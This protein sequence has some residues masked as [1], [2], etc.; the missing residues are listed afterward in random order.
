MASKEVRNVI[1]F[2]ADNFHHVSNMD[3]GV[4]IANTVFCQDGVVRNLGETSM[5]NTFG[6]LLEK[7]W[8]WEQRR[9]AREKRHAA[10][11]KRAEKV[12]AEKKEREKRVRAEKAASEFKD[13]KGDAI[14]LEQGG[15]R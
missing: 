5:A 3:W 4:H 15:C 6:E 9:I 13:F 8:D 11:K 12:A 1:R 10:N 2:A 7:M 14:P